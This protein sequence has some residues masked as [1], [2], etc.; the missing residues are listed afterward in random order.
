MFVEHSDMDRF[1]APTSPEAVSFRTIKN[2]AFWDDNAS[3]T[4]LMGLCASYVALT[5]FIGGQDLYISPRNGVE[6]FQSLR[7]YSFDALH[8]LIAQSRRELPPGGYTMAC[9]VAGDSLL[10]MLATDGNTSY[11]LGL[12]PPTPTRRSSSSSSQ[13]ET[14]SPYVPHSLRT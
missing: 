11:L 1:Y 4:T 12:H 14:D 2:D 10:A 6:L 7:S 9:Q 5:R 3:R 13:P 8:N